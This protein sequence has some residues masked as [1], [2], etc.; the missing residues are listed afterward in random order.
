MGACASA[1]RADASGSGSG[2]AH[3]PVSVPPA[4]LASAPSARA[5]SKIPASDDA[6]RLSG[7]P[8][9]S[10]EAS[11][12]SNAADEAT[13]GDQLAP[14]D[15]GDSR[16][17]SPAPIGALVPRSARSS[18]DA[19]LDRWPA[20]LEAY[21]GPAHVA[22]PEWRRPRAIASYR[23]I[24]KVGQGTYGAV[25]RAWDF[26]RGVTV[27]LKKIS[28]MDAD[29][30]TLRFATR[31]I[32]VLR[33][34]AGHPRVVS[35]LDVAL[36]PDEDAMYLA[37]EFVA[38]DLAGLLSAT[39]RGGMRV[40]QVKDVAH[41]I[42]TALKHCH[43]LGVMH[44]D[45]KGSNV[46]VANDG[47]CVLADFGLAVMR[48]RRGR[49]ADAE[50][51]DDAEGSGEHSHGR[52]ASGDGVLL[53][54]PRR[55][56]MTSRVITL[57]YRPPELLLGSQRYGAEVDMWSA[58]CLLAELLLGAPLFSGA[59]E[60]EQLHKIFK[61]C[62]SDGAAALAAR[63]GGY[64]VGAPN[65]PYE[66]VVRDLFE[67]LP[68]DAIDLVDKLLSLDPAS[69]GSAAEAL[70][71]PFFA[72]GEP[73]E[74][75]TLKHLPSSH[76]LETRSREH[77]QRRVGGPPVPRLS[78]NPLRAGEWEDE[79]AV[80][81][82][83]ARAR[84]ERRARA[85]AGAPET[86]GAAGEAFDEAWRIR[87]SG[88]RSR[89]RARSFSFSWGHAAASAER[90]AR[91]SIFGGGL[92]TGWTG[93]PVAGVVGGGLPKKDKLGSRPETRSKS[94][95]EARFAQS[96]DSA[97]GVLDD[98][99]FN[100]DVSTSSDGAEAAGREAAPAQRA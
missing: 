47:S 25:Y 79:R 43:E 21:L 9:S 46:L 22:S 4:A 88:E 60:V 10:P 98:G 75:L 5:A 84:A 2:E 11:V 3:A 51:S 37:F 63:D 40:G 67:G 8:E 32:S 99:T 17:P 44:R 78:I 90:K 92:G 27:A 52:R 41:Q 62:G 82:V 24:A 73:R 39:E 15:A 80:G 71:H 30:E 23:K 33:H 70:A 38:H 35:L 69:R 50:K 26:H 100:S 68:P 20:W 28:L 55:E 7:R 58:G 97:R 42:F 91:T 45:V 83:T 59:T 77:R 48:E 57:W 86:D 87:Q 53:D 66:R 12:V 95:G 6:A 93:A 96:E 34:V 16:A 61:T 65:R 14:S 54:S 74:P 81:R 19:Y 1:P 72:S 56:P 89:S 31:E 29:V 76:E 36:T 18:P 13:L 94:L 49:D 64:P 85:S